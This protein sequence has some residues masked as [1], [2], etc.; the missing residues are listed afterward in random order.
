MQREWI[1]P[2][3]LGLSDA[4]LALVGGQR[5]VAEALA[6][7]GFTDVEAAQAF[8]DPDAYQPASPYELPG[9]ARAVERLRMALERRE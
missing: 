7:R 8:L 4:L 9:M 3:P 2:T 6:R 1:D 5:I